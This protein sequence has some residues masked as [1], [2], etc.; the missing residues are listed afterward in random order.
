MICII[1]YELGNK[2]SIKNALSRAGFNSFISNS[3]TEI[4]KADSL[5]LPGVGSFKEGMENLKRL[6]L[7]EILT[8]EVIENKKKILGI[9]LGFQLMANK[10]FENGETKGL[11]WINNKIESI[12]VSKYKLPHVGWNETKKKHESPLIKNLDENC[13]F[14][15]NHTFAMRENHDEKF[16][17][18]MSCE[19]ED[20]FISLGVK[21][22]I[23]GIQPHPEKSQL[24]GIQ[25][26][27]NCFK[28]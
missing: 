20:Q 18:I 14:Y 25:F 13:L 8:K 17:T 6:N 16:Q 11:G 7:I 12:N 22:N 3:I 19:Y 4:K 15:Y 1:D 23:I 9:C 10:S 27:K 26:L 21:E 5:I 2:L 24:N 28:K